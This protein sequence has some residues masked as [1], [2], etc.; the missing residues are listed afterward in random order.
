VDVQALDVALIVGFALLICYLA[1]L[2]PSRRAARLNPVDG[3][4]YA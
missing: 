2:Y 3:F 1:T 4:R